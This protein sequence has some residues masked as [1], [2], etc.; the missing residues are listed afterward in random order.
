MNTGRTMSYSDILTPIV[1][2]KRKT[3]DKLILEKMN[4]KINNA[5]FRDIFKPIEIRGKKKKSLLRNYNKGSTALN[6]PRESFST[7]PFCDETINDLPNKTLEFKNPLQTITTE[8]LKTSMLFTRDEDN[9]SY[10]PNLLKT[11]KN[12]SLSTALR[13]YGLTDSRKDSKKVFDFPTDINC[14]TEVL[15]TS[16]KNQEEVNY[17]T[18]G[19][20]MIKDYQYSTLVTGECATPEIDEFV[21][22]LPNEKPNTKVNSST[23]IQPK[24]G[25]LNPTYNDCER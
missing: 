12:S 24:Q 14:T 11:I 6:N 2:T 16:L 4:R 21:C 15:Q 23:Y 1:K 13:S 22:L 8:N 19:N 9:Y 18:P 7:I 3:K 25:D 17:R 10:K 20:I 5:P